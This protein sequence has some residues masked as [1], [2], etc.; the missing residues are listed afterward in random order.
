ML[1][2]SGLRL[3]GLL[4]DCH[5]T[6]YG[7]GTLRRPNDLFAPAA[8]DDGSAATALN[9][10]SLLIEAAGSPGTDRDTQALVAQAGELVAELHQLLAGHPDA[11]IDELLGR[12]S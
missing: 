2:P 8:V 6:V 7:P 12:L 3:R 10:I 1:T 11:V 9:Y 5:L 4:V